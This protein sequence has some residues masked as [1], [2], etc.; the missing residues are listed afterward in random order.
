MPRL[1]RDVYERDGVA[2][3]LIGLALALRFVLHP[4]VG[5]H[6]P[7]F[8][9]FVAIIL[10]AGYGGYGPSILAVVLS[11]LLV[12]ALFL[13]SSTNPHLFHSRVEIAVAFFSVGLTVTLLGGGLRTARRRLWASNIE[14][15]QALEFQQAQ[16]EWHAIT[17]SSIADAVITTDPKGRVVF[18]NPVALRLTGW[19]FA[20][21]EG[22]P[23]GEVFRTVQASS[24]RT[25]DLPIARVVGG[26]EVILSDDEVLLVPRHGEPV[27]VEHNAAPI[28]DAEGKI[29]GAVIIFRDVTERH[30][31][32]QAQHESDERFRQ[33]AE[34][35][36]D[37]FWINETDGPRTTYVS[38][39]Y[40][41]LWGRSCKSLEERP[42]SYL[43]AV[44][45]ED[46]EGS[47]WLTRG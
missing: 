28:K 36:N 25:D 17:L 46:R 39:A 12:D 16:R 15:R 19:S 23:L 13:S 44:H 5:D 2:L 37:V 14:L 33:L 6:F 8:L 9:F 24:F 26:G 47:S 1:S 41:K 3:F 31:A 7:F 32:E 20:E 4:V 22:R 43:E 11:W 38:P 30:R 18:L 34:N 35:I 29:K 40:E 27:S 45:P 21:A 42:M 10:A